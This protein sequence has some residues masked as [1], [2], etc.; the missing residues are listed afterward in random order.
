[1]IGGNLMERKVDSKVVFEGKIF[2]VT[3]DDVFIEKTQ[4]MA[5][6]EIVH[7]HGGVGMVA[8]H[9]GCVLLVKQ[10]RYSI[11]DYT[12][13]IPAGKLE[14][15]EDPMVSAIRELE[16]ETGYKAHDVSK[17][18]TILATPGYCN[19]HLHIYLTKSLTKVEN[20]RLGDED[21]DLEIAWYPLET[22]MKMIQDGQIVDAK[23]VIGILYLKAQ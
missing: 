2:K 11:G 19:E 3:H 16:E 6:R 13:E 12:L 10:Y 4:T 9:E 8:Y 15:G 18:S 17:I 5:K 21:E 22:C 20:P 1:M 23:T 14:F 7:H